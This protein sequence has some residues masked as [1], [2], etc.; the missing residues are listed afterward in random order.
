MSRTGH[1]EQ[2]EQLVP[3]RGWPDAYE[4]IVR[5]HLPMTEGRL[6]HPADRFTDLGLDSVATVAMVMDIE[7]KFALDFP[8]DLLVAETFASI[9]SLWD[10]LVTLQA[11]P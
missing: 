1:L 11:A 7:D 10:V 5:R 3:E 4:E 8:D 6:L 2:L 9:G